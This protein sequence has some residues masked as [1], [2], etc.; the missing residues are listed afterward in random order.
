MNQG[1]GQALPARHVQPTHRQ[2]SRYLVVLSAGELPVARLLLDNHQ[3]VAEFD[4]TTEE[5]TSMIR[6]LAPASGA[7]G[8]EWDAALAGHS[9]DERAGALVYALEI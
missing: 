2:V 7:T 3:Q 1:F 8:P 6:G 9:R 5:V 4:A